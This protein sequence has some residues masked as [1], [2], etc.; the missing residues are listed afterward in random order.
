MCISKNEISQRIA[1]W[2]S[3]KALIEEAQ[4]NLKAIEY[5][6]I[7]FLEETEECEAKDK[8]GKPIRQFIGSDFKAT[9]AEQSRE[10]VD[11]EEV[12]KLLTEEDFQ[13]VRKESHFGVLRIK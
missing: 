7:E 4:N 5:E 1:D 2:R 12:K 9:Y 3:L 8:K 11:K 13:K 10:T 6:V